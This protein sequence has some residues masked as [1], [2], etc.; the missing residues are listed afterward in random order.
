MRIRAF[1]AAVLLTVLGSGCSDDIN[2]GAKSAGGSIESQEISLGIQHGAPSASDQSKEITPV[3]LS[4]DF[5]VCVNSSLPINVNFDSIGDFTPGN[6]R[7]GIDSEFR[8]IDYGVGTRFDN[9]LPFASR[10]KVSSTAHHVYFAD[11]RKLGVTFVKVIG[12]SKTP[13]AEIRFSYP[14][15]DALSARYVDMIAAN[16]LGCKAIRTS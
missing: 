11:D 16:L 10:S 3:V 13:N 14:I 1:I 9:E 6:I 7:I 2:R 4:T 5:G 12:V 8:R 15:A